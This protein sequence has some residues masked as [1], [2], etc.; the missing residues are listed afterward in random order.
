MSIKIVT[1]KTP[2]RSH[3]ENAVGQERRTIFNALMKAM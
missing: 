1:V 3:N 2:A